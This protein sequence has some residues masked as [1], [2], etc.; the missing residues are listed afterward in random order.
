MK[1][2]VTA[3]PRGRRR[4]ALAAAIAAASVA[5]ALAAGATPAHAS[6]TVAH[7][8]GSSIN[9]EGSSLQNAAQNNFWVPSVFDTSNGC[10]SGAPSVTYKSDGSGCGIAAMGGGSAASGC[11]SA[12]NT[13]VAGYRDP[14]TRY[15]GSDA[16]MTPA[17]KA[18]AEAAA[19]ANPGLLHTIPVASAAITVVVNPPAGCELLDPGTGTAANG[20]GSTNGNTSTGGVNDPTGLPTGDKFAD[21]D[22]RVHITAAELENIWDGTASTWGDVWGANISGAPTSAQAPGGAT[23]QTYPVRRLVRRDGS[24]TTFNFKAYLGLLPGTPAGLWTTAPVQGDNN[25]WPVTTSS[26]TTP[27]DVVANVCTSGGYICKA[28]ANGGGSLAAAVTATDGSI[29]Y[30][31]LATAR[32][33]GFDVTKS[34]TPPDH[35]YWIPLETVQPGNGNL[36]TSGRFIEPT[37]DKTAHINGGSGALGA[38]CTSADYRNIPTTPASDPTLGDWS[39]AIATGSVNGNTSTYPVCALTYDFAFDDD[40]TAYGN[41][42]SEQLQ[43]R[44]VKDYLTAVVSNIGQF[45]L[46]SADYGTLPASIVQL[47]QN[48]VNAIDWNKAANAGNGGTGGGGGGGGNN[49]TTTTTT[50]TTTGPPSN[51][52]SITGTSVRSGKIVLNATLPGPGTIAVTI[53][54]P[55]GLAVASLPAQSVGGGAGTLTLMP[56]S[57]AKTLLAQRHRLTVT[58]AVTFTPTGGSPNAKSEQVTLIQAATA[59][60]HKKHKKHKK[61]K[62]GKKGKKH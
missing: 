53:T 40:A 21:K 38:N 41:T 36:V 59:K 34:Q 60:K 14:L 28:A 22:L 17:Q 9:G 10:G 49:N 54:G 51:Q 15:S 47:A 37:A 5:V 23:C 33:K 18:N 25:T 55:N 50:T 2:P 19:S 30:L 46:A 27:P 42:M 62:K 6:F 3:T 20:A 48:G 26:N 11:L 24:G 13:G 39:T 12:G 8:G 1:P 4:G 52:F 31:D 32:Q 58:V 44:T 57:R 29:G 7:C 61:A 16:P 45:G 43:A 35:T 56:T